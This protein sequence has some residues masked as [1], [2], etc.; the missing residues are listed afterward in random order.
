MKVPAPRKLPSGN[1]FI[2]LRLGG[3]SIPITAPTARDCTRQATLIKAEYLA[4]KRTVQKSGLTLRQAC[5]RY[6]AAQEKA[7]HSPETVRG[8]DII[9]R[10]RFQSVMDL[11]VSSI[12]NWQKVYDA[13]AVRLSPKTMENTWRFIRS[14]CRHECGI[15]LPEISTVKRARPEH[16]FLEPEQIT[17]FVSEAAKDKHAIPLLLCLSSCRSSEVQGLDWSQVDLEHDR[18]RIAQTMVQN[19]SREYV[20]KAEAKTE[21]STRY[22]PLFI[23]E[24]KAAL[25][26]VP[27]KTGKVVVVRPNAVYRRANQICERLGLPLVG[28]HGLR[29]SFASLCFSL[30]VPAKITQQIGGWKDDQIVM[31]IYTHLSQKHLQDQ[32]DKLN[33]F[34]QNVNENV[35][36]HAGTA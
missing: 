32:L 11:P 1:Y 10:N 13:D 6:I 31:E 22:I 4:G 19:K 27:E 30:D 15:I 26:A 23:P 14:V 3:E 2:R 7:K 35:N 24:L 34:F 25:Q 8:Y 28:Q 18:I 17:L 16:T 33:R 36:N 29:H 21:E 12:T 20:S 5:E 9:M